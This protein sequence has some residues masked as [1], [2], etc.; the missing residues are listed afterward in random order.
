MTES[1]EQYTH[2][3][4]INDSEEEKKK[5]RKQQADSSHHMSAFSKVLLWE[6][7]MTVSINRKSTQSI[8]SKRTYLALPNLF[9]T[10]PCWMVECFA[11]AP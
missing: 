6:G 7:V 3:F 4:I 10:L 11:G 2:F 9:F 1:G 5:R 8:R